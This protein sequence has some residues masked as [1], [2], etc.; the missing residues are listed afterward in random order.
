MA[1]AQ[2]EPLRLARKVRRTLAAGAMIVVFAAGVLKLLDLPGFAYA[3]STWT[4]VPH[5]LRPAV[6]IFTPIVEVALTGAWLAGIRPRRCEQATIGLIAL[7]TILFALQ[8]AL[9][10]APTCGCLGAVARYVKGVSEAKF[11]VAR[12]VALIGALMVGGVPAR[13]ATTRVVA[14]RAV[15]PTAFTLIETLLVIA[16]IALLTALLAPSLAGTRESARRLKSLANLRGHATT[17]ASYA[18][19]YKDLF[20]ALSDPRATSSIVRCESAGIAVSTVYFAATECW[21]IGLADQYYS[22]NWNSSSFKTPW[23]PTE[24]SG[25]LSYQL[26]CS[27]LAAPSY[28]VF[29]STSPPPMNLKPMKLSDT[30]FPSDKGLFVAVSRWDYWPDPGFPKQRFHGATM[31]GSAL[32]F[33]GSSLGPQ[34]GPGDGNYLQYTTHYPATDPMMHSAGGLQG[35]DL[36]SR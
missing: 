33:S 3:V 18:A 29:P 19:D 1:V 22:G 17:I 32:F 13:R 25:A 24:I 34:F 6:A 23:T 2:A 26:T 31:D 27:A 10:S 14:S 16:V 15:A 11:V 30:A 28:F 36:L 7:F 4:I 5:G 9:W 8:W 20:P 21:H 35:R 12:N